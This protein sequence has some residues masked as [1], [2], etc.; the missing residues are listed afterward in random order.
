V[1]RSTAVVRCPCARAMWGASRQAGCEQDSAASHRIPSCRPRAS[2]EWTSAYSAFVL[3]G[4]DGSSRSWASGAAVDVG[5]IPRVCT[6]LL[7][8]IAEAEARA[9]ERLESKVVVTFTE[10][11]M[12]S[13]YDLLTLA[14]KTEV[15]DSLSWHPTSTLPIFLVFETVATAL[16][17]PGSRVD[18]LDPIWHATWSGAGNGGD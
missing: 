8:R 13:A 6:A 1:R 9:E 11:Y 15:T 12:E 2:A 7:H 14:S 5:L 3:A 18:R 10:L 4:W 17:Q 16:H